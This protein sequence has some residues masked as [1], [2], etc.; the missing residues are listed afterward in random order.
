[1]CVLA[2]AVRLVTLPLAFVSVAVDMP[3]G[4]LAMSL[5]VL[6]VALVPS[7]VGPHLN[8]EAMTH[9]VLPLATIASPVI[10]DE[11]RPLLALRMILWLRC[12]ALSVPVL[13]RLRS[14]LSLEVLAASHADA[15]DV[16]SALGTLVD[17]CRLHISKGLWADFH[18]SEQL[19]PDRV[20]ASPSL[21][22]DN[23]VLEALGS[24]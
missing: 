18:V 2:V 4:A 16:V 15:G 22:A 6:P 13:F 21:N 14:H 1:M 17:V 3:E 9:I 7:S 20:A 12:L 19:P 23:Q 11:L 5:V 24:L 10:K 8:S